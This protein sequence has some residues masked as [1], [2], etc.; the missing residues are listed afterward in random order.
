MLLLYVLESGYL[1][2]FLIYF[3]FRLFKY[4]LHGFFMFIIVKDILWSLWIVISLLVFFCSLFVYCEHF[5][6]WSQDGGDA[7][8]ECLPDYIV[9]R[10]KYSTDSVVTFSSSCIKIE[11]YWKAETF[12]FQWGV[13]HIMNIECQW[14]ERVSY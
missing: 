10:D 13:D 8:V 7:V 12:E 11:G 2:T 14:C 3:L 5:S 6:M 9:Y 4:V 1:V